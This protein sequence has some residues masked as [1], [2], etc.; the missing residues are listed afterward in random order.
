MIGQFAAGCSMID[1][2]LLASVLVDHALAAEL[3]PWAC[4][5]DFG[6]DGRCRLLELAAG[7]VHSL[8]YCDGPDTLE[9]GFDATVHDGLRGV[10]DD[11]STPRRPRMFG[12]L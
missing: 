12:R 2:D 11:D 4:P 8:V 1:R 3:V 5:C 6:P 10:R 9:R 7:S